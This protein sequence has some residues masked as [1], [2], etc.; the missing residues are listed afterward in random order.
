MKIECDAFE[1][2]K[3]MESIQF[4]RFCPFGHDDCQKPE[5]YNCLNDMIDWKIVDEEQPEWCTDCKEYDQK[6]HCC[7][8]W[9]NQIRRTIDDLKN[10]Y[11]NNGKW[12]SI[13]NTVTV[14]CS[15]C[16]HKYI[17]SEAMEYNYCPNCGAK[18]REE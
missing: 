9:T 17:K 15:R 4:S 5:C 11:H 1:K 10:N 3:L 8:R 2:I 12:N 16:L 18:M 6:A 14:E 7:H 13:K